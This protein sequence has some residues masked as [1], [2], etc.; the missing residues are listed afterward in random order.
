MSG[1]AFASWWVDGAGAPYEAGELMEKKAGFPYGISAG[2][3]IALVALAW[4]ARGYIE[5]VGVGAVAPDFEYPTVEGEM[6]SLSQHRGKVVLLN[7]WATW[8]GPCRMEMPSMQRLYDEL[9]DDGL[10]ILAVSVDVRP[11]ETDAGGNPGGDVAEFARSLD[12]T[13][14]ILLNPAGDIQRTYQT[15]GVPETF[16]IGPDGKIYRKVS[17]GT[18]WDAPAYREQIQR[19]LEQAG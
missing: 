15:T 3:A 10:E 12:L 7:V 1:R 5:P 2:L 17:G 13:F 18:E 11:G 14:P 19:L 6:Q 8:C 9:A 16:L 4:F